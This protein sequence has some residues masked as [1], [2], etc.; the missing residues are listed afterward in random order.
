M[1]NASNIIGAEPHLHADGTLYGLRLPSRPTTVNDM[2]NRELAARDA[3]LRDV[4]RCSCGCSESHLITERVRLTIDGRSVRV[5]S[6]GTVNLTAS[7]EATI[8]LNG[9]STPRTVAAY[10]RAAEEAL[11]WCETYTA[12]ELLASI[13]AARKTHLRAIEREARAHAAKASP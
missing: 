12:A 13:E 11:P 9:G 2:G 4:A 5:W 1:R 6:D 8:G 7:G 10:R 3:Y